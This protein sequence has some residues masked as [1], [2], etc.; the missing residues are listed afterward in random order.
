MDISANKLKLIADEYRVMG[1]IEVFDVNGK[2][3]Y[4][5]KND[6]VGP[7]NNDSCGALE[8]NY[9]WIAEDVGI[10][11]VTPSGLATIPFP[12]GYSISSVITELISKMAPDI[13]ETISREYGIQKFQEKCSKWFKDRKP[14]INLEFN[15]TSADNTYGIKLKI[16]TTFE[17]SLGIWND[18][19][20]KWFLKVDSGQ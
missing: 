5:H 13:I 11:I 19:K 14:Y 7:F 8:Q 9:L 18:N 15:D 12:N 20:K 6:I 17:Q 3:Y 4:K 1:S 16:G 2:T 10:I